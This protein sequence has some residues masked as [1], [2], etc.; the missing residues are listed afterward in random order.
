M[1]RV[2]VDGKKGFNVKLDSS[3]DFEFYSDESTRSIPQNHED[4]QIIS[5]P[6]GAASITAVEGYLN[7]KKAA[8]T[9]WLNTTEQGNKETTV[10]Y[11]L[12]MHYFK[13][14]LV[15]LHGL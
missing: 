5:D 14:A 15:L 13:L 1:V 4:Y 6:N 10:G 12:S 9:S 11:S 8:W 2:E 3:S 7:P